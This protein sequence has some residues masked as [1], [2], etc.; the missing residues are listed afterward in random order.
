MRAEEKKMCELVLA[1]GTVMSKD[2]YNTVEGISVES[3]TV[4]LLGEEYILTK[5]D[6]EW[7]YFY[8]R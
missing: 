2:E 7:V 3:Y 4:E 8:H 6:G 1:E 5:N